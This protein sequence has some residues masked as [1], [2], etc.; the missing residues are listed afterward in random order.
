MESISLSAA[1][2]RVLK[3]QAIDEGWENHEDMIKDILLTALD[4]HAD[5]TLLVAS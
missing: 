3:K 2:M 5:E 1:F 4:I